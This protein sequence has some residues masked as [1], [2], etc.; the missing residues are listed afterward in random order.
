MRDFRSRILR[1]AALLST[2]LLATLLVGCEGDNG[3]DGAAG[4]NGV[5]GAD[6]TAGVNCWDLNGNGIGDPEEDLNGDGVVDVFDCNPT[7]SGAYATDQLHV[8]YFT[9]HDYVGTK[10]CLN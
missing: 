9:E 6:G 10:S 2:V 1:L 8:G 3:A 4:L 5:P 7:A